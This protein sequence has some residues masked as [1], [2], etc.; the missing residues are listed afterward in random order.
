[1]KNNI[2]ADSSKSCTG[3][4]ACSV[5]CPKDAISISLN[6]DGFYSATVDEK[7]CINCGICQTIC[8]RFISSESNSKRMEDCCVAGLFSSSPNIQE[9][10]TSGGIA[11]ELS[12]WG[13][14]QG[15]QIFG[16]KYNYHN[17][18]AQGVLIKKIEDLE[19]LKGSKYLQ[20][21]ISSALFTLINDAKRNPSNKYICIGTPC[22]I[23]GLKHLI[24]QKKL[25]NDFLLIDLFCH[26][27]PSYNVWKPYVTN[28]HKKIGTF[29]NINFRYKGNGWHQYTIKIDGEKNIYQEFAYKDIFYRFFFDNV[30]LNSSCFTCELRK[31]FVASDLRLGDF[32]GKNYEHRE[33]GISAVLIVTDKGKLWIDKMLQEKRIILDNY[34][35]AKTCLAAQSTHN[36]QNLKLRDEVLHLLYTGIDLPYVLRWYTQR[37]PIRHQI[38]TIIK[39]C[40]RILPIK[41][42]IWL[43]RIYRQ[44]VI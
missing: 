33:D 36:Y 27:V 29:K 17:D 11:Y 37:L 13:I 15:Y 7:K 6:Q 26:G 24:E 32:L 14:E 4:S 5:V 8:N 42:L 39:Q 19:L 10:T 30:A 41:Y 38:L 23:F 9:S 2:L 1:M 20:A 44:K 34:W 25:K 28:M 12:K 43:R 40:V 22:Q 16:V 31:T 18:E 3:C 21:N 35:N